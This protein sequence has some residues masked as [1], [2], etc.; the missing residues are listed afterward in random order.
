MKHLDKLKEERAIEF[1]KNK[2][3]PHVHHNKR[4]RGFAVNL[5]SAG[6]TDCQDEMMKVVGGLRSHLNNILKDLENL[7]YGEEADSWEME[8]EDYICISIRQALAKLRDVTDG[9]ETIT[10]GADDYAYG[11]ESTEQVTEGLEG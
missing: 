1:I 6:W 11:A 4:E 3:S 9:S 8:P 2:C 7:G 10:Q 5:Y